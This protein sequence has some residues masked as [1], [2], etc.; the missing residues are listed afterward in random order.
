MWSGILQ[1]INLVIGIADKLTGFFLKRADESEKRR[2][3]AQEKMNEAAKA[4][5]YD[6]FWNAWSSKRGA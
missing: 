5:K 4:G 1:L 3:E 2:R 6:D